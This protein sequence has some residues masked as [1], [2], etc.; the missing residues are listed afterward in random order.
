[1]SF[2]ERK[3]V[4]AVAAW[5]AV[6]AATANAQVTYLTQDRSITAETSYDANVQT[7]SAG[8]FGPFAAA[9]D[10]EV[11]FTTPDGEA[12]VNEAHAGIDCQLDPNA[13]VASGNLSAGGGLALV[14]GESTLVFGEAA[15][16]IQTSFAI[17]DATPF[18]LMAS[19][20]PSSDPK[21]RFKIKLEDQ[22]NN[23]VLFYLDETMAAQ[24]VDVAGLL[25]PGQYALEYQVEFTIWGPETLSDFY[26]KMEI[27]APG[28]MGLA[29][30]GALFSA[31]RRRG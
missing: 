20:R 24:V 31:R 12:G 18:R 5:A 28:T 8:D 4:A 3:S 25:A 10:L 14:G 2:I 23:I 13:I 9:V 7:V 30:A 1:M 21:D 6:G 11:G 22:I 16:A 19:P 15:A 17:T 27:P 26:F 29:A